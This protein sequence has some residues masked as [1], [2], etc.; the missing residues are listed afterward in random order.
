MFRCAHLNCI[1]YGFPV[2]FSF[3]FFSVSLVIFSI[4]FF[5]LLLLTVAYLFVVSMG[6]TA[7]INLYA[8]PLLCFII[9][10]FEY[11]SLV[12]VHL[13]CFCSALTILFLFFLL[14][15]SISFPVCNRPPAQFHNLIFLCDPLMAFEFFQANYA[16][17]C[18][19]IVYIAYARNV[20]MW[21]NNFCHVL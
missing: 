1:D 6:C 13:S 19:N 21:K 8:L 18:I 16:F 15:L 10:F 11:L 3:R 5:A 17:K 14:F 12:P 9:F 7:Y 2:G 20:L 4:H